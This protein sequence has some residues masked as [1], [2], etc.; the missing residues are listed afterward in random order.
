MDNRAVAPVIGI[1]LLLALT[2][3]CAGAIALFVTGMTDLRSTPTVVIEGTVDTAE[4]NITLVHVSGDPITVEH[5]DIRITIDDEPLQ[6]QP[7]VQS[8]SATGFSTGPSGP[9]HKWGGDTWSPGESSVISIAH[10]S[11]YP[12]PHPDARVEVSLTYDNRPLAEITLDHE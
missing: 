8:T 3:I 4:N 6:H 2:V 12:L 1:V 11:N 7:P 5:L 9:L 10:T